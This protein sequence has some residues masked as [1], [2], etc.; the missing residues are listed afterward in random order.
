MPRI[1]TATVNPALDLARSV[2]QVIVGSKLGCGS[3]RTDFG[4]VNRARAITKLGAAA[5]AFDR[6]RGCSFAI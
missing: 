6:C 2:A 3:V 5:A 1:L 4:G